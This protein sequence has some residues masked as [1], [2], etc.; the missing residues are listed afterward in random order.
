MRTPRCRPRAARR[1][2]CSPRRAPACR[3]CC[4]SGATCASS[5]VMPVGDV[6]DEQHEIGAA[7]GLGSACAL[8]F[9]ASAG[10]SP[11]RPASPSASQPPVST[12]RNVRPVHSADELPAVAGDA[13]A[14]LDDRGAPADDAVHER[15]L[16]D[17]RAADDGDDGELAHD[18][19]DRDRDRSRAAQRVHE[20]R[21]VGRHDLDRR[22][23]ARAA[24]VPSRKRPRESATSGSR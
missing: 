10:S 6:D 5:S 19:D 7:H 18:V 1:R 16:A 14:L 17:V 12:M 21:A 20:R 22:A 15:R 8:T 13:R 11:V 24:V 2:P 23:A 9:A 3:D 4:S